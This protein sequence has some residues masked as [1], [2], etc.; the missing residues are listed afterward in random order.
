M[1]NGNGSG[2]NEETLTIQEVQFKVRPWPKYKAGDI[3][4]DNEAGALNQTFLENLRNNF[5]KTVKEGKEAEVGIEI[6]Q[7]QFDDYVSEYE[8]GERR[9]GGFRGDPVMTLAMN[10][11]RE[12][13]RNTIKA[14]GLN[15]DDFPAQRITQAAKALL[16]AQGENGKIVTTARERVAAEQE[17]ARAAMTEVEDILNASPEAAE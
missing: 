8:F 12:L 9:S 4:K 16:D 7:Q 13:I 2:N 5:S 14:K 11:A 6:L 3:L 15:T 17:A 1:P 10:V